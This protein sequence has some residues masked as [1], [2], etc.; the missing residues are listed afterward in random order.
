MSM[1]SSFVGPPT[2]SRVLE[3]IA[4]ASADYAFVE[5]TDH[6]AVGGVT[7]V[8]QNF[9]IFFLVRPSKE[10]TVSQASWFVGTANGNID[11]GLYSSDGTTLTRVARTGSVAAAGASAIQTAALDAP[12]TLLPGTDYYIALV[13]DSATLTLGRVLGTAAVNLLDKTGILKAVT[14]A[15]LPGL[16]ASSTIAS[17]NQGATATSWIRLRP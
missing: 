4:D 5:T 10:I 11:V 6:R 9:G 1:L 2:L 16:P 12:A 7:A 3:E 8:G 13:T 15:T 14:F 17:L